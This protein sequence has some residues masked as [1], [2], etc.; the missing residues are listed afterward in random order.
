[1]SKTQIEG[2]IYKSFWAVQFWLRYKDANVNAHITGVYLVIYYLYK[3]TKKAVFELYENLQ[4]SIA[5]FY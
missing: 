3:K 2:R 1:M 4:S 5:I